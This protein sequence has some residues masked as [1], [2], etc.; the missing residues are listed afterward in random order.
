M[1]LDINGYNADFNAFI[2]FAADHIATNDKAVARFEVG[3]A[4]FGGARTVVAADPQAD[5]VGK[6]RDQNQRDL[7][8]TIRTA[9]RN[10]VINMFGGESRIPDSVKDAMLLKDY[11]KGKP[12]T[13]RRILAVKTAIDQ[14]GS[15]KLNTFR[16]ADAAT[17]AL[18]KGWTNEE[19]PMVARAARFLSEAT[20]VDEFTAIDQ[21]ST[22]GSKANRLMNYG[23]RF[24]DSATNFANGLRLMEGFKEWFTDIC[25]TMRPV[26]EQNYKTRDYSPADTFTKLNFNSRMLDMDYL[27]GLEKFAFE[28]LAVSPKADLAGTDME[29]LFGFK[30]NK[31][32]YCLGTAHGKS[33]YSTIAN[34]P[35]EKRAVLYAVFNAFTIPAKNAQEAHDKNQGNGSAT[36]L[37]D[38]YAPAMAGRILKNFDKDE[39][40]YNAGKLTAKNIIKQFFNEI[41]DKGDYDYETLNNYFEDVFYKF[42]LDEEEGGQYTDISSIAGL[43]LE[44][45]GCTFEETVRI[46]REGRMPPVPKYLS[47]GCMPLS[48]F[49][50]TVAGGRDLIN[51][52]LDRPDL[53]YRFKTDLSTALINHQQQPGFGFTFPGQEKFYTNSS[54]Q[55]KANITR[56]GDNVVAM[57]GAVHV[58]QANAVMTLLS[59]SGLSNLRGGLPQVGSTGNEHAPV[60]YTLTKNARTGAVTIKYN[61]PEALPFKFEW[62]A[63]VDIDGNITTT[64]MTVEKKPL[65]AD[66]A[67]TAVGNAVAR[68]NVKLD[69]AQKAKATK[70]VGDLALEHNLRGK[71]LDLFSNFVV[72]LFLTDQSAASDLDIATDMA[73]NIAAWRKIA[74]PADRV[75]SIENV[76][77]QNFN[78][79]IDTALAEAQKADTKHFN[80]EDP[81][82]NNQL[83]ADAERYVYTVNGQVFDREVGDKL[84]SAFKAAIKGQANLR[85]LSTIVTQTASNALSMLTN[86]ASLA[87]TDKSPDG[88]STNLPGIERYVSRDFASGKYQMLTTI[89]SNFS[90]KFEPM[91]LDLTVA[92]DGKSATFVSRNKFPLAMGAGP[93]IQASY[94]KVELQATFKVD[95]SGPKPI[96]TDCE[97]NQDFA[98]D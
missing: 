19:L 13:A 52:D 17:V 22:P 27:L 39:A 9:F 10:A 61:S 5:K 23:G 75:K 55:G 71:K 96:V 51:G 76:F 72:R 37:K 41:P 67:A 77:V 26:H 74:T 18:N 30:N 33:I 68:Q 47:T 35:K 92:K 14:D 90:G 50:G 11:N 97:I 66:M 2:Q 87:S 57:C 6:F 65:P 82:I 31:A 89:S 79:Q 70:L 81:D 85:G 83:Y 46:L 95:L 93:N 49:D 32:M 58:A 44:N 54:E 94:G 36:W 88:H 7:N 42:N 25:N 53:C 63:T 24:M 8:N 20:V 64:P 34:I 62:S 80:G 91:Y 69:D 12:L 21:L 4:P 38:T 3:A 16:S 28:E 15:V 84:A 48:K 98:I 43:N 29:K 73:K 1:A 78:E 40:L 45:S 60:D 56:V 86:R 59:Q